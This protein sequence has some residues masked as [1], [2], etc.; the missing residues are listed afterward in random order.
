MCG[1]ILD[2]TESL[3]VAEKDDGPLYLLL[4][5]GGFNHCEQLALQT[6]LHAL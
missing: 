3:R 2:L 5:A 6:F 1:R 4:L